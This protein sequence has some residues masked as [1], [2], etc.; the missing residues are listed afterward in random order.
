MN[1][2]VLSFSFYLNIIVRVNCSALYGY[3]YMEPIMRPRTPVNSFWFNALLNRIHQRRCKP[4]GCML[5]NKCMLST[6]VN[7]PCHF[8]LCNTRIAHLLCTRAVVKRNTILNMNNPKYNTQQSCRERERESCYT[9]DLKTIFKL[10]TNNKLPRREFRTLLNWYTV[11]SFLETMRILLP[12]NSWSVASHVF[13][14][15]E[16]RYVSV[17]TNVHVNQFES[18]H[19]WLS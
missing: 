17:C 14:V 4:P 13:T 12:G 18:G 15:K 6:A 1:V 10:H 5:L 9:K 16:F 3:T 11:S 19:L 8:N 2:D 7:L